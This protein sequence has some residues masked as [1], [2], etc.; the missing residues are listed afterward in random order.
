MTNCALLSTQSEAMTMPD[1]KPL[2]PQE[3]QIGAI[4]ALFDEHSQAI[5]DRFEQRHAAIH[6]RFEAG[7]ARM[8]AFDTG[9]SEVRISI[10]EVS[11][12]VANLTRLSADSAGVITEVHEFLLAGK[13]VFRVS[14]WIGRTLTRVFLLLGKVAAAGLALWGIYYTL[15]H[16]GKPPQ[17]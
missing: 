2:T 6:D 15:T 1:A 12:S 17:G 13:N 4:R 3:I 9:I 8:S 5:Y 16:G 14:S 10:E 11:S 7:D